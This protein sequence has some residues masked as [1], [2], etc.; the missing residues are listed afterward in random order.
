MCIGAILVTASSPAVAHRIGVG[1]YHFVNR[2]YLFL[3][4]SLIVMVLVSMLSVQNVRR[5]AIFGFLASIGLMLLLPLV[6]VDTKGSKRWLTLVGISVQ[7]S[8]FLKPCMAVV[9]AWIF[10]I[11][12]KYTEFPGWRISVALYGLVVLLLLIQPDLGMVITVSAMWGVQFFLAGMP[13]IWVVLMVFTAPLGLWGAYS[14]FP[15][16]KKRIDNF[17]DPAVGDNYQVEK[18]R[19]AFANGGFF[20]M[21]PGEGQVKGS[22]PDSHTDF[23]YAVAGEEFGLLF[24]L[25]I[26]ALF[27]FIVLRG[28]TNIM[29]E[30]DSFIM[31]AVSGLLTQFGIQAMINMG[32]AV[33]LL[34]AKGM[35][36]PLISYG[37]SSLIAIALG[38]GMMLALTRRRFGT[39]VSKRA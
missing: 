26:L 4:L 14:F 39:A 21:G 23:V 10:Y 11:R 36:L 37:G 30:K 32:V 33:N 5:L 2:Q 24:C 13:L 25:L 22:L 35:T 12:A 17:M 27:A 34:P 20:G 18:S 38:M 16:V 6:G 19:E 31:I 9:V 15:H 1:Q 29:N 7:P 8:E 28:M 3:T